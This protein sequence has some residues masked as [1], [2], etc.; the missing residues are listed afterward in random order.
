[1][2]LTTRLSAFLEASYGGAVIVTHS[3]SETD[4]SSMLVATSVPIER[5]VPALALSYP[6]SLAPTVTGAWMI[7]EAATGIELIITQPGESPQTIDCNFMVLSGE[8]I[9]L[10]INNYNNIDVAFKISAVGQ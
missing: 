4:T 3:F 2:Y 9:S 1:M 5:T 6:V 7:F 10:A 8:V